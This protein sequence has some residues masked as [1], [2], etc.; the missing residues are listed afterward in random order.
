MQKVAFIQSDE[1]FNQPLQDQYL[2]NI[3]V[4]TSTDAKEIY[5]F[6]KKNAL[7][8]CILKY[9][10][11]INSNVLDKLIDYISLKRDKCSC[12]SIIEKCTLM[13]TRSNATNVREKNILKKTNIFF[14]LTTIGLILNTYTDNRLFVVS[15]IDSP[16]YNEIFNFKKTNNIRISDL[17]VDTL[18]Q[19]KGSSITCAL[20][21][22]DEYSKYISLILQS[23]YRRLCQFFEIKYLEIVKSLDKVVFSINTISAG[24]SLIGNMLD[25]PELDIYKTYDNTSLMLV[26]QP[27]LWEMFIKNKIVSNQI[28][29]YGVMFSIVLKY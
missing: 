20:D 1:F 4:L 13:A 8:K 9:V 12:C 22:P 10:L 24:S 26:N 7:K 21:T 25:Y 27:F 28:C 5:K 6:I 3:P 29:N 11:D 17:T 14:T 23:N 18:N 19:Y 16:Y 15:D 2:H